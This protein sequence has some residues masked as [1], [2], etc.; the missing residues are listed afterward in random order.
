MYVYTPMRLG[1]TPSTAAPP[2]SL[3]EVTS[4][5]LDTLSP[6]EC[7]T[8]QT[9]A[10]RRTLET[11]ATLVTL[12]NPMESVYL[13]LKGTLSIRTLSGQDAH[14]MIAIM[15]AGDILSYFTGEFPHRAVVTLTALQPSDLLWLNVADFQ[16][17][18]QTI[19]AFSY[20][21]AHHLAHRLIA[22]EYRFFAT[23]RRGV[24]ERL[25]YCLLAL[26]HRHG[27]NLENGSVI[28]PFSLTQRDLA[29]MIGASRI[30]VNH[31]IQMLKRQ[32]VLSV[33]EENQLVIHQPEVLE[34]L[35]A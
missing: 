27:Q 18:L 28:I 11:G 26:S 1:Y 22:K 12:S 29:A 23:L 8:I 24:L 33:A 6:D 7:A 21:V 31:T 19:P 10:T 3:C 34:R 25:A 35:C 13:I 5:L 30:R 16:R 9:L 17:C 4:P 32:G 15:G 14:E 20:A 2:L